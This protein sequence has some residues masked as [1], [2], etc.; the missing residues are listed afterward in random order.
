MIVALSNSKGGVGKSTL[1]VHLAVSW[2]EQGPGVAL[3]WPDGNAAKFNARLEDMKFGLVAD[4]QFEITGGP[5]QR[6][7]RLHLR[8]VLAEEEVWFQQRAS[9]G[10][11]LDIG[12]LARGKLKGDPTLLRLGN[13]AK[14][15]AWRDHSSPGP[16][17]ECAIHDVRI[18][19]K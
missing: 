4:G 16:A 7:E 5:I 12:R 10:T 17:G 15:G 11:W 9:N 2:H 13:H 18:L 8:L 1:A 3:V 14:N 6:E 19:G